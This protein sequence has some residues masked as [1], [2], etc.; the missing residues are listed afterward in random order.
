[1]KIYYWSPFFTN[2][3]TIKAVICSA[4]SL[5]KYPSKKKFQVSIIDTIG[6]WDDYKN[7]INKHIN[8]IKLNKFKIINYL[9]KNSFI[10]SR[11]SYLIIFFLNFTKLKNLINKDKPDYLI[12]H[13]LTSLPIFL[14]LFFNK[15][16]KI[17]LRISG[18]P[19]INTMRYLFWK[20]FSKRIYKVTCPTKS[21]YEFL[22]KK[23][24]FK[25][26]KITILRDP[27]INIQDY[28]SK[29][30]E[31][32]DIDEL[33][34]SKFIVGIGRLTAQK[35]FTLLIKF[36]EKISYKYK[37]YKLVIIGEGEQKSKLKQMIKNTVIEKKVFI[38]GH[39]KNVYKFLLNSQCFILS[40]L[41]EDPGFV[42]VEAA[43]A[44]TTIISSK[45]PNGPEEIVQNDGFLFEN[46]NLND[47][48]NKFEQF[49]CTNNDTIYQNK[50]NLKKRIKKFTQF[51]HYKNLNLI[52]H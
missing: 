23:K 24:I 15:K 52:L 2:I 4:E 1:M 10:K 32:I 18:L 39:Q 13:L 46:N 41:W 21:T 43:L 47:L 26:E 22:I 27:I 50:F 11:I 33:K 45:C 14:S 16:T 29:K 25:K 42:I 7:I 3:A 28:L 48:V 37:D 49:T 34:K 51:Q 19:K 31:K 5:I 40:S 6:E 20:L 9:P 36:F 44:N 8:I 12:I 17:L 30:K 35:N 38:I